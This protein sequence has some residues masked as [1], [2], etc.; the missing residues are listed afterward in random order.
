MRLPPYCIL[1]VVLLLT[2]GSAIARTGP[3]PFFFIQ[4]A[5]TQF[6]MFTNNQGFEKET[7]LFEK[8][9]SEANQLKPAFV[10][11]CGDLINKPGDPEQRKELLRI[12]AKLDKYIPLHLVS[13]NHD[14]GGEPT[15]ESLALYR[16][17][18]GKDLYSFEHNGTIGIVL[19]STVIHHPDLALKAYDDQLAWL[20]KELTRARA[21]NPAHIF[22]FQHHSYF[23][24]KPDE[25]DQ[26]FNIPLERR[27]VYL[28]LFKE[29][30]VRAVFSGHYHRNAYGTDESLEMIT[31]G[32]VGRPLGTDPSGFRIVTVYPDHM[33]HV[34]YGM[35]AMP[36][37]V[38]ME[39]AAKMEQAGQ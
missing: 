16:K 37:S 11:I 2:A 17:T 21:K 3:K 28:E 31:T 12:A 15:P 18:I 26:Y 8:A 19:N 24:E 27:R 35:D 25:A 34:Y 29:Y 20:R 7:A 4:M 10:V 22:I 9:I 33:E 5:D 38:K 1:F 14:V 30:G 6:G 23:L 13:G 32:P 36:D 39:P